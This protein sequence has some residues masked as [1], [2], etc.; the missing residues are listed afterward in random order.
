M[1]SERIGHR[2]RLY[3]RRQSLRREISGGG[4]GGGCGVGEIM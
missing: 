3:R 2:G 1:G 4:G